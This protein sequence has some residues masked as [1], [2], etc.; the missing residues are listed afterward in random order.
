M[1]RDFCGSSTS[2][3]AGL[4]YLTI[5]TD[6]TTG[7]VTASLLW[8]GIL[9]S[10]ATEFGW[11]LLDVVLSKIQFVRPCRMTSKGRISA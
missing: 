6:P 8:K 1:A 9:S 5:L 11:F 2:F 10:G 3:K 4:F 7:G